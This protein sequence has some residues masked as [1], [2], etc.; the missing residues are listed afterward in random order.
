ML[1]WHKVLMGTL[2]I[3]GLLLGFMVGRGHAEEPFILRLPSEDA[4]TLPFT[5]LDDLQ[6]LSGQQSQGCQGLE[7]DGQDFL[8]IA[9]DNRV[10]KLMTVDHR[11]WAVLRLVKGGMDWL[12]H[13][14]TNE[15]QLVVKIHHSEPFEE[16]HRSMS[17]C[18]FFRENGPKT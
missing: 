8:A 11:R 10:Y 9:K 18:P 5:S 15:D 6:V 17:P 1:G 4:A 13:L 3:G 7:G 2:A 12:W 16:K 14:E